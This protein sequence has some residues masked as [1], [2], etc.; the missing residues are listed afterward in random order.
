MTKEKRPFLPINTEERFEQALDYIATHAVALGELVL[1]EKYPIDTL[2]LFTR[3][4]NEYYFL[5]HLV[6]ARGE[7]SSLTHGPT[8]YIDC[9][10]MIGDNSIKYL[11][12]RRPDDTRTEV[13]YADYPVDDFEGL[14]EAQAANK[15]AMFMR[16]G[17]GQPMLELRH[18]DFD[19]RGYVVNA[20]DH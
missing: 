1:G 9:D 10:F 2:T 20:A 14:R 6:K 15:H 7:R 17:L 13:G 11:G 12:L 4:N 18:P 8:L 16:S 3:S 19:V 5:E